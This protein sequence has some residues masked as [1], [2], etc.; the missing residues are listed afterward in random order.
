MEEVVLKVE[1]EG[2]LESVLSAT[3]LATK[4]GNDLNHLKGDIQSL[5]ELIKLFMLIKK[6]WGH[7]SIKRKNP[8]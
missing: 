2:L 5:K 8:N 6:V 1:E 7:L 4:V 3:S